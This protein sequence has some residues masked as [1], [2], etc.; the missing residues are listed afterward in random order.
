MP[1]PQIFSDT[2]GSNPLATGG[3]DGGWKRVE[4][5]EDGIGPGKGDAIPKS[6][7]RLPRPRIL[8]QQKKLANSNPINLNRKEIGRTIYPE[9]PN[10]SAYV[11]MGQPQSQGVGQYFYAPNEGN[12]TKNIAWRS[13]LILA[14]G[15]LGGDSG[16]LVTG[17]V[18]SKGQWS[19]SD[20]NVELGEDGYPRYDSDSNFARRPKTW[21][22]KH[23]DKDV[24]MIPQPNQTSSPEPPSQFDIGNESMFYPIQGAKS[25]RKKAKERKARGE[26]DRI[27][28]SKEAKAKAPKAEAPKAEA[29]TGANQFTMTQ[30]HVDEE[31]GSGVVVVKD[32]ATG[33]EVL[34]YGMLQGNPVMKPTYDNSKDGKQWIAAMETVLRN[35]GDVLPEWVTIDPNLPAPPSEVTDRLGSLKPKNQPAQEEPALKPGE[36]PKDMGEQEQLFRNVDWWVN[37]YDIQPGSSLNKEAIPILEKKPKGEGKYFKWDYGKIG[38]TNDYVLT[39]VRKPAWRKIQEAG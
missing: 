33:A 16:T 29:K 25:R 37:E 5:A 3:E 34:Q 15:G 7:S 27:K 4:T 24:S 8:T 20:L 6:V 9:N 17:P 30:H 18:D 19:D 13:G 32:S 11:G 1:Q 21:R 2:Q 39:I 26:R 35:L 31:T 10:P 12:L 36:I 28:K 14:D 22:F 38:E 23:K